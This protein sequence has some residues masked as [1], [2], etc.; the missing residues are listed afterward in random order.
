[1]LYGGKFDGVVGV[2]GALE[3][4]RVLSENSIPTRHP[5]EVVIFVEEEGS[6]FMS[7]MA[8]SKAMIGEYGPEELKKIVNDN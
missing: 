8:G 4:I 1:V 6:N 5:V 7:T 3:V 2:V